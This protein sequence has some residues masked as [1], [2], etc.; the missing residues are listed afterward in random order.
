MEKFELSLPAS[1]TFVG[2]IIVTDPCYFIPRNIWEELCDAWYD[3]PELSK[4]AEQGI[5]TF[6]SG[7]KV[8]YTVTA[9]GDGE[10]PIYLERGNGESVHADSTGVDAGMIAVISVDDVR[11]LNPKF[12]VNDDQ[13]PRINDF[14]GIIKADGKGNLTGDIEVNTQEEPI[15]PWDDDLDFNW[16][17]QDRFPDYED[18]M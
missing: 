10:Y 17:Q 9:H 1:L 11:K 12:N 18:D 4:Y 5:I 16:D 15:E 6:N 7:V 2:D 3:T 13:Y 8:L 14:E